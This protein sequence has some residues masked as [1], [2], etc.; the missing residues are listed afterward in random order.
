MASRAQ[1]DA[2][3]SIP[4]VTIAASDAGLLD[5][6]VGSGRTSFDADAVADEF[7]AGT[8]AALGTDEEQVREGEV[9]SEF[10]AE[11]EVEDE[12]GAGPGGAEA[13]VLVIMV[14]DETSETVNSSVVATDVVRRGVGDFEDSVGGL[15]GEVAG[16]QAEFGGDPGDI[17]D[18]KGLNLSD[19]GDG[20]EHGD[21]GGVG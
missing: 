12:L 15:V 21:A 6:G 19:G 3:T 8:T 9:L 4:V 10:L 18:V 13:D 5:S 17:T 14:D 7:V 16:D 11:S 20:D 1:L 2:A